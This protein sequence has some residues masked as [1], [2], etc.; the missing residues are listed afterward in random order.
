MLRKSAVLA[1]LSCL[2]FSGMALGQSPTKPLTNDDVVAMVKGHLADNTIISAI[3]SQDS[4]FD[5]SAAAL[6]KL[7]QAGVKP[8]VLDAM[9]AAAGKQR[10]AAQ[11]GAQAQAPQATFQ[12]ALQQA[13]NQ[14][15]AAPAANPNLPLVALVQ[16]AAKQN[17][18]PSRTQVAQ[19]KE[20]VSTLSALAQSGALTQAL[21]SVAMTAATSA[22]MKGNPAGINMMPMAAPMTTL[23]Q[24]FMS[25]H[26]PTVTDV[27]ALPG[28]KAEMVLHTN[29]PSFDVHYESIPGIN[30]AEYEP[31][32][33]K[34]EPTPNNFRLVGATQA[35]Q[36]A[37]ET[38]AADWG[39][40]SS[41][42][43][44]RI[45]SQ[46]ERVS[47][48]NYHV[49]P[50]A[51]LAAGEYGIAL[52]PVNKNKKFSGSSIAQNVG[53]GLIFDSVWAFEVR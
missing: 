33:L 9:I 31:V 50:S 36:D 24:T 35:K 37:M 18:T 26:K 10:A 27:W 11:A 15:Q 3:Q 6:L 7:N 21:N 32:L 25:H 19:T 29:Q 5:V 23:A 46:V 2:I 47:D 43:E 49:Q 1:A 30:P 22:A 41:F 51:T 45:A 16:G 34:L 52:R 42:V 39:M 13:M 53:D 40:Y 28:Q 20:K 4:S 12:Q 14:A 8:G 17:L 44:E 38:A 48:G